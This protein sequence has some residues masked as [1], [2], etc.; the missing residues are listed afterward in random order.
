MIKGRNGKLEELARA[1]GGRYMKV[2]PTREG[3]L[4]VVDAVRGG[5]GGVP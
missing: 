2:E 3:G 1:A 4:R 5:G